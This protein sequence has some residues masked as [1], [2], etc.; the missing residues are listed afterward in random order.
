MEFFNV[1]PNPIYGIHSPIAL[2]YLT[3]FRVGLSHLRSHKYLHNFSDT[4]STSCSCSN[5][6]PETIEHYLL[7]C[8]LYHLIRSELFEKLRQIISLITLISPSY[9]SNLL[10]FGNSSF[11]FHTNRKILELTISFIISSNRF[12]GAFIAND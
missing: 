11:D 10:L 3:R 7:H 12:E 8:P 2:K 5:N 9:T 6:T 4:T 1:S